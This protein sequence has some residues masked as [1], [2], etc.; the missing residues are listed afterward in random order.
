[1]AVSS[2]AAAE[3]AMVVVEAALPALHSQMTH[4]VTSPLSFLSR[5]ILIRMHGRC[6]A[7]WSA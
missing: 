2:L 7:A 1:M 4:L 3:V 5:A 6:V